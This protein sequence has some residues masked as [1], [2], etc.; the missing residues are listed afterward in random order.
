MKVETKT[1]EPESISLPWHWLDPICGL[2]LGRLIGHNSAY[3]KKGCSCMT[4]TSSENYFQ[5]YCWNTWYRYTATLFRHE[6]IR[7]C[8]SNSNTPVVAVFCTLHLRIEM[9]RVMKKAGFPMRSDTNQALKPHKMI[10]EEQWVH[11]LCSAQSKGAD[12]LHCYRASDLRLLYRICKRQV[13]SWH[14]SNTLSYTWNVMALDLDFTLAFNEKMSNRSSDH[15]Q[16]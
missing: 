5:E 13:F 10:Y 6:H 2:H 16:T 4:F 8:Y 3:V 1:Q 15:V 7:S 12:Q 14:D 9:I 11:Y